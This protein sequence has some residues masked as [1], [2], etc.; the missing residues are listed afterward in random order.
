MAGT[1]SVRSI[2][3][4]EL[5][6]AVSPAT[7]E[8]AR[9][10]RLRH[11]GGA[12]A[13]MFYGSCLRQPDGDL[14]DALLDF[15]LL[16]DDY[17]AAYEHAWLAIANRLL[18]PNVFY[19]ETDWPGGRLRAKYV[20]ISLT[21]FVRGC[22]EETENV[23]I[24]ARFSQ[25]ARLVWSRDPAT[26]ERVVD[27]C[28]AAVRTMLGRVRPL[29][30]GTT[31]AETLWVRA[32]K[33]TYAAELRAESGERARQIYDADRDRYV[34]L[35]AA[36]VA[37]SPPPACTSEQAEQEWRR[38]RR[39]GKLLNYARLAKA[40]FTFDGGVDYVMWKVRRHSGV[41]IPVTDWQR[42][43]PLLSAPCLAWRLYRRGAFR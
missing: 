43:H 17:R 3:A 36:V 14:G 41:V 26:A 32:F 27:A 15:Y 40:A 25:P 9:T 4:A 8:L 11:A 37:E 35:A 2:V 34:Q 1:N 29:L 33:E 19:C 38:R 23:S 13:V 10:I 30:A 5:G 21:D 18:P 42:R 31:D 7:A 12:V 28:A 39:L 16:V 20:V 6:Q 22:G 24:W